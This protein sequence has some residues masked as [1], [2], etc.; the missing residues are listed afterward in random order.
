ME[1]HS[2]SSRVP[3]HG[4]PR[5]TAGRWPPEDSIPNWLWCPAGDFGVGRKLNGISE[6]LQ[7]LA[8]QLEDFLVP[9][10]NQDRLLYVRF[11]LHMARAEL[12]SDLNAVV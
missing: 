2:H 12:I 5:A 3:R 6:R 11:N 10:P 7:K 1:R 4:F 9:D 8:N